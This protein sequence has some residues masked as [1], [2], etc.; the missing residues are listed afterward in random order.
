MEGYSSPTD[1]GQ[2]AW[3]HMS[4]REL[5]SGILHFTCSSCDRSLYQDPRNGALS[6]N[7]QGDVSVTHMGAMLADYWQPLAP[8]SSPEYN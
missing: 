8:E 6:V 1:E 5:P 4:S 3:H 7:R 2:T